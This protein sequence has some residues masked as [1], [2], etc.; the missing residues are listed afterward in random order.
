MAGIIHS[1]T[2]NPLV[3]D[4]DAIIAAA[5]PKVLTGVTFFSPTAVRLDFAPVDLPA[6]A[7]A[8]TKVTV[9]P[10]VAPPK[11]H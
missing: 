7:A 5:L 3:D 1:R 9:P 2:Y 11:H 6:P 8:P 4:L 10:Y